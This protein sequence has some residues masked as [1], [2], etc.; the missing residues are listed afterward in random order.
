MI[1]TLR[2]FASVR[3]ALNVSSEVLALPDQIATVGA[4]RNLLIAR[5]GNWSETLSEHR[6]IRVAYNQE[7]VD[8][9]TRVF[10]GGELA[11]FPPVTGG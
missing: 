5:G 1:L 11:F 3:E 2:Y 4:V 10:D 9:S 8:A 6:N 7:M